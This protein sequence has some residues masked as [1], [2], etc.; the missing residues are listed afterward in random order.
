ML[1][2]SNLRVISSKSNGLDIHSFIASQAR[3]SQIHATEGRRTREAWDHHVGKSESGQQRQNAPI[4]SAWTSGFDTPILKARTANTAGK[5]GHREKESKTQ[6][7]SRHNATNADDEVGT[8]T[9]RRKKDN[10]PPQ[11]TPPPKSK[12]KPAKGSPKDPPNKKKTS[13]KE[14]KKR[15]AYDTDDEQTH[16]TSAN[17]DAYA[18]AN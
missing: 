14:L 7:K 13:A 6:S 17:C 2:S 4:A 16:R 1:T 5:D 8:D 18:S 15:P 3:F 10:T 9:R 12:S 11:A